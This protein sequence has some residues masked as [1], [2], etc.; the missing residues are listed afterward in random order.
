M[1]ETTPDLTNATLAWIERWTRETWESIETGIDFS[2]ERAVSTA[3]SLHV[4][5]ERY[6]I[7]GKTYRRLW[8]LSNP[9]AE[10]LIEVLL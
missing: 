7:G 8:P 2:Q 5:E 1:S 6:L 3:S 4:Y 10:P 9:T